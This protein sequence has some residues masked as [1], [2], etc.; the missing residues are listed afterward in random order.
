MNE[1]IK[2]NVEGK[3]YTP[4][5]PMLIPLWHDY[6]IPI[7]HLLD[8]WEVVPVLIEMLGTF[9]REGSCSSVLAGETNM[10][11][12]TVSKLAKVDLLSHSV[13]VTHAMLNKLRAKY[14]WDAEFRINSQKVIYAGMGHDISKLPSFIRGNPDDHPC[15]SSDIMKGLFMKYGAKPSWLNEVIEAVNEHHG[16]EPKSNKNLTSLLQQAD[17]RTREMELFARLKSDTYYLNTPPVKKSKCDEW[18]DC[19]QLQWDIYWAT[20]QIDYR[21]GRKVLNAISS[22][23]TV[24]VRPK[25]LYSCAK[26]IYRKKKNVL[27]FLFE[28]KNQ[29]AVVQA[30]REVIKLMYLRNLLREDFDPKLSPD[31][32]WYILK[33]PHNRGRFF[34]RLIPIPI[35]QFETTGKKLRRRANEYVKSISVRRCNF[36]FLQDDPEDKFREWTG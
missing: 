20:N 35:Y 25:F 7:L 32:D 10:E 1:D 36:D 34:K 33:S 18:L 29:Y 6:I 16:R 9:E 31:G 30:T 15:H 13:Y 24:Y 17:F 22:R 11:K 14:E 27:D 28:Y 8:G 2:V 3:R 23:D 26:S 12:S 21:S 19:R 5:E 4:R